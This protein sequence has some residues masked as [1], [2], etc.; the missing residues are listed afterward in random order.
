MTMEVD[1]LCSAVQ[2]FRVIWDLSHPQ[3]Y[4]R[5][6]VG[7]AWRDIAAKLGASGEYSPGIPVAVLSALF[8]CIYSVL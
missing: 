2:S 6:V 8:C 3:H 1:I 5:V 7:E 4:D